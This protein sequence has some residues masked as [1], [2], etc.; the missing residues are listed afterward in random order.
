MEYLRIRYTDGIANGNCGGDD[1]QQAEITNNTTESR[2]GS[3]YVPEVCRDSC[4]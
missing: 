3:Y 4:V 2:R 1:E